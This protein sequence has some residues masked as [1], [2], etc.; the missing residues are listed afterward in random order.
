M[1]LSIMRMLYALAMNANTETVVVAR[2]LIS[3][4]GCSKSSDFIVP[5]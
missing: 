4:P 2:A 1:D 5:R 3:R